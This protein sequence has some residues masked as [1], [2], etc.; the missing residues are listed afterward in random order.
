MPRLTAKMISGSWLEHCRSAL[1]LG[2]DTPAEAHCGGSPKR[3]PNDMLEH[4][5]ILVPSNPGTRI[6]SDQ[7]SLHQFVGIEPGE[8]RC[9][10]LR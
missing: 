9:I 2:P 7:Q 6:V 4:R 5:T 3:N 1:E 8:A 10:S